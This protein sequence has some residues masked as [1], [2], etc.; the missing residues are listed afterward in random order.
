MLGNDSRLALQ[1]SFLGNTELDNAAK[2]YLKH[3]FPDFYF[4][5]FNKIPFASGNIGSINFFTDHYITDNNILVYYKEREFMFEFTDNSL[6]EKSMDDYLG[7][8]VNKIETVYLEQEEQVR[9]LSQEE[10]ER[11]P[12]DA[13]KLFSD[14]GN[15]NYADV[16]KYLKQKRSQV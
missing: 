16:L 12:G 2:H 4:D 9:E 7:S 13:N 3:E 14:P 11:L 1:E 15:V 10:Q 6:K 5:K 8:I